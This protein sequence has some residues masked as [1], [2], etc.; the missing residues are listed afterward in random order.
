MVPMG[1]HEGTLLREKK[2]FLKNKEWDVTEF[3]VGLQS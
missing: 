3:L 1:A 2:L